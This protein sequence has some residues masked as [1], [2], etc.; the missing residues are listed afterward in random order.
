MKKKFTQKQIVDAITSAN[1]NLSTAAL[2]LGCDRTTIYNYIQAY[3]KIQA[4]VDEARYK[5]D[6][7]I[8]SVF[9]KKV[10]EGH[11]QELI[12]YMKTRMRN[13]GYIEKVTIEHT[14]DGFIDAWKQLS[15]DEQLTLVER[16]EKESESFGA[17]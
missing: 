4:S 16:I 1:G 17:N 7:E 14:V 10:L 6:D 3:P 8:E 2:K 15:P 12:F 13:R 9:H 11:T 5:L